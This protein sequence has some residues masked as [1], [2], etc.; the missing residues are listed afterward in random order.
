MNRKE[1]NH[2]SSSYSGKSEVNDPN[3]LVFTTPDLPPLSL[4]CLTVTI[5]FLV[6]SMP[7]V[8]GFNSTSNQDQTQE[9]IPS[10]ASLWNFQERGD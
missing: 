8:W 1:F 6:G 3:K 5:S 7:L 4:V 10:E 9:I 2:R